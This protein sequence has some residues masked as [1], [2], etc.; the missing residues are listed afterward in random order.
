VRRIRLPPFGGQLELNLNFR[1]AT[2]QPDIP[3]GAGFTLARAPL[4]ALGD[5]IMSEITKPPADWSLHLDL[6]VN[7]LTNALGKRRLIS[8][9]SYVRNNKRVYAGV[10][11][12]DKLKDISWTGNM[13]PADLRQQV[14]TDS[15]RLI[16][17]DAFWDT[18]KNQVRCA[19]IWIKNSEGWKWNFDVDLAP[20]DI[21]NRLSKEKGKL[22]CLRVYTRPKVDTKP[23]KT[24]EK[25]C[26][27]W[28]PDDG[29]PWNWDPDISVSALELKLDDDSARLVSID[30]HTP[31]TWLP[32]GEKLAA[33]WW[34]NDSGAVWFWNIGLD[35]TALNKE[36]PKFCSYGL[37][38]VPA[39]PTQFASIMCQ[40]PIKPDAKEANLI[41]WSGSATGTFRADLWEDITWSLQQQNLTTATLNYTNA[42]MCF[43]R[44]KAAGAG[45]GRTS[46]ILRIPVR[47]T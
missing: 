17:L 34:K 38:V 15:G 32:K 29:K 35:K 45:G 47:R 10:S 19:G 9:K 6:S 33:V 37:D 41:T 22:T 42:I 46:W 24:E 2:T 11:V 43:R 4:F 30:N 26:A 21:T 36:F 1:F 39:G 13:K 44:P 18:S 28:I 40:F 25:Y 5:W 12:S 3:R 20:G 8:I 31:D 7:D 23:P 16:S 27:I 14:K